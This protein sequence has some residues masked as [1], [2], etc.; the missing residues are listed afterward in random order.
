MN[1]LKNNI[2]DNINNPRAAAHSSL[3]AVLKCGKYSNLEIDSALSRYDFASAEDRALYTRLVYGVTEKLITLDSIISELSS[4]D[5]A[6]LDIETLT[7]LRLGLYQ[8]VY[9]DRIPEHAAVCE[10]VETAPKRSRGFVNACLRSFIRR[11]KT[12][13]LPSGDD[14]H[15]LSVRH[16]VSEDICRIM[17]D[18]YGEKTVDRIL[19][20]MSSDTGVTLR[21]NTARIGVCE[22]I[23]L[24]SA[25]GSSV[26][27]GSYMPD[28]LKLSRLEEEAR[29]GL[30]RGDWFVQD[31]ASRIASYIV[32]AK[33]GDLIADVCAAPGGKTFSL[34]IDSFPNGRI[35]SFD[36]R[37]NKLSL[38][39]NGAER[40][41]LSEMISVQCRDGREPKRELVGACD[42]VLCDA[43][44]SGF[45]VMAKKPELRLR[46]AE[47]AERLPAVQRE[48]LCGAAEYVKIGGVLVY[49]TCTLN[50]KENEDTVRYFLDTH[51]EFEPYD[52]ICPSSDGHE[53]IVS[54][55]GCAT[56]Y[57]H[58][59]GTDGFFIA[60]LRRRG[61]EWELENEK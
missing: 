40:L 2:N 46:S 17:C 23:K 27:P 5:I 15:S 36:V 7:S 49:S 42:R 18:S 59:S 34:A 12:F 52:F 9:T 19:G 22:A 61:T 29:L 14:V 44:C 30:L 21:I 38:I 16:S 11:G 20:A 56:V 58:K 24:L 43:P 54:S 13:S 48:V 57:P 37:K 53:D 41:G 10:T 55:D 6:S 1:T 8:L 51:P 50:R 25:D 60:R 4:R 33:S 28:V 31:E 47:S 45:G 3:V 39:S 26:T 32:N 35:N